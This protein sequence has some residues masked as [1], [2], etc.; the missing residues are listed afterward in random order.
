MKAKKTLSL[1]FVTLFVSLS[2]Y[3]QNELETFKLDNG[4]TV[5]LWP[6]G[7][8]PDVTGVVVEIGRAHV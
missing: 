5:Y 6:D 1:L 2:G 4:L 8:Q 7:N 3:A